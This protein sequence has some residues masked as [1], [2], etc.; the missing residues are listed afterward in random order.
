MKTLLI[1]GP[2]D[3]G[4]IEDDGKSDH[5]AVTPALPLKTYPVTPGHVIK[6]HYTRRRLPGYKERFVFAHES[7]TMEDVMEKLVENYRPRKWANE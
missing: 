7:L 1:G 4:H 5:H 3:G 6:E 2:F